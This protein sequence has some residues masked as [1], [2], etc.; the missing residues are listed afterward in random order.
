VEHTK[1]NIFII[2]TTTW[3]TFSKLLQIRPDPTS[4]KTLSPL[5]SCHYGSFGYFKLLLKYIVNLILTV[6]QS[7]Y[8]TY[9]GLCYELCRRSVNWNNCTHR[10]WTVLKNRLAVAATSR[11]YQNVVSC[12]LSCCLFNC[13]PFEKNG[14]I[15]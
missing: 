13:L 7:M 6:L 3:L 2:R 15:Q 5:Y 8:G 11:R 12:Y 9:S 4:Q 14:L 10:A 1:V